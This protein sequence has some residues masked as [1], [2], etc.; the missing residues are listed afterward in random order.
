MSLFLTIKQLCVSFLRSNVK[1][2]MSCITTIYFINYRILSNVKELR[3]FPNLT[4]ATS[5]Q[6]LRLDRS[7]LKDVPSN[8]CKQCPKLKSL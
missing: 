3:H 8:L 2:I 6:V 1:T 4:G 5:L 7:Q